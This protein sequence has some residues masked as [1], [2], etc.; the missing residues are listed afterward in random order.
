VAGGLLAVAVT[1]P[2][3]FD[4]ESRRWLT[5]PHAMVEPRKATGLVSVPAAALVA[6]RQ[7]LA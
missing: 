2:E 6:E 7:S 4:E 5:L 1:P 3:L